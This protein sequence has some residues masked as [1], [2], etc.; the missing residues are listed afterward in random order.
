MGLH[1]ASLRIAGRARRVHG[2]GRDTATAC[3]VPWRGCRRL[4]TGVSRGMRR[5]LRI[6]WPRRLSD[7][8]LCR[9]LPRLKLVHICPQGYNVLPQQVDGPNELLQQ[10]R[11]VIW[12]LSHWLMLLLA[13]TWQRLLCSSLLAMQVGLP[14]RSRLRVGTLVCAP[15]HDRWHTV[16][17]AA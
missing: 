9:L 14:A 13:A 4:E 6:R 1:G 2:H 12:R 15:H 5:V 3:S 11:H 8:A 10:Q 17:I 16:S 7:S